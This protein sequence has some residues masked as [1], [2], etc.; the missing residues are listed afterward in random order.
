MSLV[1][2]ISK[3]SGS[4]KYRRYEEWLHRSGEEIEAIDLSTSK[5][6]EQDMAR[7]DALLLTGG[8]DV[9]PLRYNQPELEPLC[10]DIDRRRD[11]LEFRLLEIAEERD[12]PVLA[13]CRGLQVLNVYFGGTL[14]AHLPNELDGRE[15]HQKDADQDRTHEVDVV[16]GTLLY[17]AVGELEG[18]VNSAH[19]QAIGRLGEGLMVSARAKD[20]IIEG[21]ERGNPSGKSYLMAVQWHPERMADQSSPFSANIREQFLFEARS[22]KILSG[23]TRPLPKAA[24]EELPLPPKEEGG[25]TGSPLLP[26][27]Q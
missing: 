17:K 6:V 3:G 20:G 16:P 13:I 26:I 25:N 7:V 15:D 9:D 21:V 4:E 2:G 27:I 8:S 10:A 22:A 24:P 19:H 1:I 5:D 18:D 23:V 14:L 11:T 12:L